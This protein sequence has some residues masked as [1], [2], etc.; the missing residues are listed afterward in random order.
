MSVSYELDLTDAIAIAV[1][2][3]TSSNLPRKE[4]KIIVLATK[5][6]M[7]KPVLTRDDRQ[8]VFLCRILFRGKKVGMEGY[9]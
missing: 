1:E 4:M 5:S 6:R 2:S 8:K 3:M 7:R 9:I